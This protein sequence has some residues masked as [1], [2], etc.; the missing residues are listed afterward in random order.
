MLV[1]RNRLF[2]AATLLAGM[3][4]LAAC[5]PDVTA[6]II[7]PD[8]GARLAAA[9]AA[10]AGTVPGG[11]VPAD[12]APAGIASLSDEQIF[13]GMD[14]ALAD[15]VRAAD[16]SDGQSVSLGNACIGCHSLD[17]NV[18]MTGPTWFNIG[19]T[20]VTRVPDQGPAEYLHQSIIA[21]NDFV[22]PD[23]PASIMPQ[24]Y[25]QTMDQEDLATMIAYLLAQQG[26]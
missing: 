24:T 21:P 12:G 11:T 9:E 14:P 26:E 4:V 19:N 3:L 1:Q 16:P 23:Y 2:W 20:A 25:D 5:A 8:L 10:E 18:Q 7:S 6:D 22:V 15:L 13:A 17:P